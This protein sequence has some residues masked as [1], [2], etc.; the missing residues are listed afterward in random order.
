MF[1]DRDLYMYSNR[2]KNVYLYFT[3]ECIA[4]VNNTDSCI[5][6]DKSIDWSTYYFSIN[7]FLLIF[8]EHEKKSRSHTHVYILTHTNTV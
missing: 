2:T 1:V 3:Y 8:S 5:M 4:I 7:S 6:I